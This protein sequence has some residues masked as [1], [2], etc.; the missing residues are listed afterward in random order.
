MDFIGATLSPTLYGHYFQQVLPSFVLC[1]AA[2]GAL[3]L[4]LTD[5]A[6]H[7]PWQGRALLLIVPCLLDFTTLND[8]RTRLQE[9]F[10]R[11]EDGPVSRFVRQ[12]TAPGDH[13]W[14]SPLSDSRFYVETGLTS[15]TPF[16]HYFIG[17]LTDTPASTREQ[18]L[19]RLKE[20]LSRNPPTWIIVGNDIEELRTVGILDRMCTEYTRAPVTDGGF[21]TP[22]HLYVRHERAGMIL[23]PGPPAR[24]EAC[25]SVY[26]NQSSDAYLKGE[27]QRSVNACVR[28]LVLDPRSVAAFNNMCVSF[29]KL[30]EIDKAVQSCEAALAIEPGNDLARNNLAWAR[31]EKNKQ[32][33]PAK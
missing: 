9:P 11:A 31:L 7:G 14:V 21:D 13:L 5:R 22:A 27:W 1:A 19:T 2:G 33:K 8:Y 30:G 3:L 20:D 26:V 16:M 17:W 24:D 4:D 23:P 15:P 12:N 10:A 6:F 32:A 29:I 25:A 18:K 28:A